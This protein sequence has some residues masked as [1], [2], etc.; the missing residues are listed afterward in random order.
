MNFHNE[1]VFVGRDF[2]GRTLVIERDAIERYCEAVAVGSSRYT[3]YAPALLLHSEC[4]EN[5]D[6][7]LRNIIG[8]LHARQEWHLYSAITPGQQVTTRGFIRE[9]YVKRNREYVV[10]ETW[11]LGGDGRLLNR[12]VTHQSFL[13]T[14]AQGDSG[15]AVNKE[16]EKSAARRFDI[17]G[18]DGAVLEPLERT[19]SQPMCMAFSG[20]IKNYHN[21]K[22]EAEKL[23]FP[24][25][26]VQGML[27]ICLISE[28]LTAEF[29]NG[30]LAGGQMDVRLVNVLWGEE[31][32][33]ARAQ[34]T[35]E[36]AE[37]GMTRV[38]L[39]VWVEKPDET[40][41]IVGKASALRR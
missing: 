9:R 39:D 24:D 34:V 1:P 40:K 28:V 16:R 41:V 37:A 25:I 26:V 21:D 18:G 38:H 31:I 8:N 17:G 7:Y 33:T 3:D 35:G 22:K 36:T 19:I 12:G 2:G 14:E 15:F 5:L 32:A 29:G 10:K 23:G 13:L 6:W 30:W 20:P 4:Y 27:P 11:V